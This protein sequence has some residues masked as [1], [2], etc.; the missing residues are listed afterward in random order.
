MPPRPEGESSGGKLRP[1]GA[2]SMTLTWWRGEVAGGSER[3]VCEGAQ[4]CTRAEQGTAACAALSPRARVSAEKDGELELRWL[5]VRMF[6]GG[7]L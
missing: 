4:I 7:L 1:Q 3:H 6:K 2:A 5:P